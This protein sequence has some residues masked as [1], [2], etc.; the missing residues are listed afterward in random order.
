MDTDK[1]PLRIDSSRNPP[2]RAVY[3]PAVFQSP[4]AIGKNGSQQSPEAAPHSLQTKGVHVST[5]ESTTPNPPMRRPSIAVA[6]STGGDGHPDVGTQHCNP[7]VLQTPLSY[8]ASRSK[9]H[10]VTSSDDV[11]GEAWIQPRRKPR[12]RTV[13]LDA[14]RLAPSPSSVRSLEPRPCHL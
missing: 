8:T 14:V 11:L 3:I 7:E 6:G 2:M 4:A 1:T 10:D 13:K 12:S 9:T 5:S